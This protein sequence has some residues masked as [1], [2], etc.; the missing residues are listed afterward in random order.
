VLRPSDLLMEI[1]YINPGYVRG[2]Q[3]ELRKKGL[4]KTLDLDSMA[5]HNTLHTVRGLK[6]EEGKFGLQCFP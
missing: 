4:T 2:A 6:D 5:I 1:K 3:E